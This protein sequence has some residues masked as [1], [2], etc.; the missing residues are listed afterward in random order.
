VEANEFQDVDADLAVAILDT[1]TRLTEIVGTAGLPDE[2]TLRRQAVLETF[3]AL[4][5]SILESIT[6]GGDDDDEEEVE[7]A[8]TEET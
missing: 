3:E 4:Y 5:F 7:K 2:H 1:A 6:G 8:P